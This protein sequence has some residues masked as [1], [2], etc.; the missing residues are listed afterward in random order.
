MPTKGRPNKKNSSI[1]HKRG[2]PKMDSIDKGDRPCPSCGEL[3]GHAVDTCNH[4]QQPVKVKRGRPSLRP[5]P[6][7]TVMNSDSRCLY[8]V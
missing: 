7:C 8:G 4:Y 5:C 2:K 3:N 1:V 6:R